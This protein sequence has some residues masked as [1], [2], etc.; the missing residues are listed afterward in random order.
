[1]SLFLLV[2]YLGVSEP[3]KQVREEQPPNESAT[4]VAANKETDLKEEEQS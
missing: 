3:E 1:M 2:R 4:Q